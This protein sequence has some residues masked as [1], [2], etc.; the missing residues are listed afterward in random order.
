MP[1]EALAHLAILV[2]RSRR[3]RTRS[4]SIVRQACFNAV[5]IAWLLTCAFPIAAY[6]TSLTGTTRELLSTE[7]ETARSCLPA[8]PAFGSCS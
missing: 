3:Q 4:R 6:S 7:P 8:E 1:A 2:D 5:R